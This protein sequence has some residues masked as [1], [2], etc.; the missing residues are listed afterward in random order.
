V[1]KPIN[2]RIL[3][4][5]D[6]PAIHEDFRKLFEV[7]GPSAQKLAATTTALFH[8]APPTEAQPL[9]KLDSAFQG[10]E[11]LQRVRAARQ[12]GQP[13]ALAFVD[14]RMPPGWDGIETITHLWEVDSELEVVICTAYSD[15]SWEQ[16]LA[17]LGHSDR[18]LILKK[19]FEKIEVLQL[20]LTLT[21]KWHLAQRARARLEELDAAV[22]Q[23][24]HELSEANEQLRQSQQTVLKQERLAAVGQIAAGIAHEFNNIMMIIGG[25]ASLLLAQADLTREG[26]ASLHD[27][28]TASDRAAGLTRQ[29]LAFS[30]QQFVRTERLDLNEWLRQ[31]APVLMTRVGTAI[32]FTLHAGPESLLLITD[33]AMLE[34]IVNSLVANG[35]DAMP[36]GGQLTITTRLREWTPDATDLPAAG[37][38]GAFACLQVADTGFGM[39]ESV[40]ARLF[41]PFFTTKDIGHGVGMGLASV[42]GMVNQLQGWIEV[43]SAP[44]QGSVFRVFLPLAQNQPT[45]APM[46]TAAQP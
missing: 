17:R 3:I 31:L 11:A 13:Y 19:P 32:R 46:T 15:Y 34:Q 43:E 21:Q 23:R 41:E 38:A 35:R 40:R 27:I 37:R 22:Q 2:R 25:N 45:P 7:P 39:G 10:Q 20:A 8:G 44:G 29:L 6:T 18:L 9:F 26:L 16:I 5:D 42:Y 4:V 1:N 33:P 36:Q 12:S 24:T 28:R 30:R 14:V